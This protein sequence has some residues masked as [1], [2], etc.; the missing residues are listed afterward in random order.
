MSTNVCRNTFLI[1]KGDYDKT[2]LE[3][4]YSTLVSGLVARILV[5]DPERRPSAREI[6]ENLTIQNESNSVTPGPNALS[7]PDTEP[8][9]DSVSL[10]KPALDEAAEGLSENLVSGKEDRKSKQV[11]R[12]VRHW[13]KDRERGIRHKIKKW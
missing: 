3:H 7:N 6:Q 1:F 8:T 11:E 4:H 5:T 10:D 12:S 2:P 13:A 9:D